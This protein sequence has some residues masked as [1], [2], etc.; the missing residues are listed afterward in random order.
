MADASDDNDTAWYLKATGEGHAFA[1]NTMETGTGPEK[2]SHRIMVRL[3]DG[4]GWPR[5]RAYRPRGSG[6]ERL[7]GTPPAGRERLS[8]PISVSIFSCSFCL[9][10]IVIAPP[11]PACFSLFSV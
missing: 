5:S 2:A 4:I 11:V 6:S 9:I 3:R 7:A 10:I 1:Q 8:E